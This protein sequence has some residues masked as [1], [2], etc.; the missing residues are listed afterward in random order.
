[1]DGLEDQAPLRPAPFR[2]TI[3]ADDLEGGGGGAPP[4]TLPALQA[5]GG[6]DS[7]SRAMA[8]WASADDAHSIRFA[9]ELQ[10]PDRGGRPPLLAEGDLNQSYISFPTTSDGGGGRADDD[11]GS[12]AATPFTSASRAGRFPR[13]ES[14]A[15]FDSN[16]PIPSP[17][18]GFR[19]NSKYGQASSA[20]MLDDLL[21]IDGPA[22]RPRAPS[23]GSVGACSSA[24]PRRPRLTLLRPRPPAPR[25]PSHAIAG[26]SRAH[27]RRI[28]KEAIARVGLVDGAQWAETLE[29]LLV[30][31]SESVQ[32]NVKAGDDIDL[33][34]YVKLKKV[35]LPPCRR[36]RYPRGLG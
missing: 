10:R 23:V 34:T 35:R 4:S 6:G 17:L 1:M 31:V 3:A 14:Q 13:T 25:E 7:T 8:A 19:Y 32:P 36:A 11:D 24:P 28:L 22:G 16:A 15:R 26:H 18:A 12:G 20:A 21:R 9:A 29:T 27:F 2:S 30:K 33:R 5:A